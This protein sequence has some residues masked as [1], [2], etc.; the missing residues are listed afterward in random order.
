[1]AWTVSISLDANSNTSGVVSVTWDS[2]GAEQ[3]TYSARHDTS[4]FSASA[5]KAAAEVKRDAF[6]VKR[7]AVAT[8][9]TALADYMNGV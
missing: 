8:K 9:E 7:E 3:F 2:G 4:T 1:M 6:L 5:F